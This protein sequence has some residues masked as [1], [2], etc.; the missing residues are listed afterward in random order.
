MCIDDGAKLSHPRG[1]DIDKKDIMIPI[2]NAN[3]AYAPRDYKKR[4]KPAIRQAVF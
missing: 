1:V 4:Q 2:S 3:L